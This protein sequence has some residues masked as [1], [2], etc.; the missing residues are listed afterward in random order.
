M[1]CKLQKTVFC[2]SMLWFSQQSNAQISL[3]K[4]YVN[5]SSA[6]IGTFQ[7]INFREGGFSSLYP[8]PNTNGKEYWT[9]SDRGVNIDAAN[10]NPASCHP[11]YDKIYGFPNYAPKIHRIRLSGDTIKIL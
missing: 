7:T 8:I 1:N 3:L 2:L 5:N 9:V 11:T 10:A 4:D 6:S